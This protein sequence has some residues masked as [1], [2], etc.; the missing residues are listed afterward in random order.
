MYKRTVGGYIG[1]GGPS[2]TCADQWGMG[3]DQVR[4]HAS[5]RWG[6][7]HSEDREV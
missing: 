3:D 4:K 1:I 6:P 7:D 2:E 5:G